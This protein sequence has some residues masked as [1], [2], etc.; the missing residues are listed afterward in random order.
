MFNTCSIFFD[1]HISMKSSSIGI[2]RCIEESILTLNKLP[3]FKILGNSYCSVY[4]ILFNC[5]IG[6]FS[7]Y[8]L[9]HYCTVFLTVNSVCVKLFFIFS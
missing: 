9:P 5:H 8:T 1:I 3:H 4:F 7:T 2:K 6:Y